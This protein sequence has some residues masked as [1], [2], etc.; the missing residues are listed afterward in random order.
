LFPTLRQEELQA[1]KKNE[2]AALRA[3]F[4]TWDKIP[5]KK[6]SIAEFICKKV[7]GSYQALTEAEQKNK[8]KDLISL[9]KEDNFLFSSIFKHVLKWTNKDNKALI[10]VFILCYL[11]EALQ[12]QSEIERLSWLR[13]LFSDYFT[14]FK[15]LTFLVDALTA[16]HK[17]QLVAYFERNDIGLSETESGV[18]VFH[19]KMRPV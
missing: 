10:I 9:L 8:M 7:I 14:S 1:V 3:L 2:K 11:D 6:E 19:L 12:R 18:C 13:E 16:Q 5:D 4:Q 17:E 15:I